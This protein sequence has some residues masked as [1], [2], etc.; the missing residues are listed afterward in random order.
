MVSFFKFGQTKYSTAIAI[1]S[2]EAVIAMPKPLKIVSSSS[3]AA[4]PQ[5]Q[6]QLPPEKTV[7]VALLQHVVKYGAEVNQIQL[8]CEICYSLRCLHRTSQ[9]H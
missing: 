6:N 8:A 5:S 4:V 7:L 3:S 2:A 1:A 9:R